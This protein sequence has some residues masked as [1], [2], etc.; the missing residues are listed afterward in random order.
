M[1]TPPPEWT[2][3]YFAPLYADVYEGP[4]ADA[5][6]TEL[7]ADFLEEVFAEVK[8]EPLLDIGCGFGRHVQPMRKRGH[9]VVGLDLYPHLIQRMS[10]R[11]RRAVCGDMR[12]LPFAEA[13]LAGAWCL[14]N[15]FGY[16]PHE[17]NLAALKDWGRVIRPEGHVVLQ[18][19]NRP[20]MGKIAEEF[21][22]SQM[23]TNDFCVTEVYDYDR[24]SKSMKGRGL[25]QFKGREQPWEFTLRMYTLKELERALGKAGFDTVEVREDFDSEEFKERASTQLILTARRR[26]ARSLP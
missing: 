22:P 24:D 21:A 6:N 4:L 26:A 7:E 12:R 2:R 25:W 15:S 9:H 20:V 11:G 19:P 13:A 14:F 5:T 23:M 3:G 17:E 18:V 1:I 10:K 16:F 8:G